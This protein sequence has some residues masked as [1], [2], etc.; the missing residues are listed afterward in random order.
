MD[1]RK[2]A[3]ALHKGAFFRLSRFSEA[4]R[5]RLLAGVKD[6]DEYC[7][8][9]NG[10]SL[11][12]LI[13]DRSQIDRTLGDY[14]LVRHSD[15]KRK[16]LGLVKHALLG[17]QH[18]FPGLKGNIP[19]AWAHVRTWEEEK[20]SK[21]RPPLPLAI[22][23]CVVGLARAHAFTAPDHKLREAWAIFSVLVEVG[24]FCLLRPGEILRLC[25]SDI[26]LPNNFVLCE[27]HAAVRILSPKNRRQFGDSQFVLLKN[28]NAISWLEKIHKENSDGLIWTKGQK[29]FGD[30]FRQLMKELKLSGCKF[31]P[32]SLR[33]GGATMYYSAGVS[34]STLRFMGRW[35]VERSLEHYIQLAMSAQIMNKLDPS[36]ITRLKRLALLCLQQVWLTETVTG[37]A[38][39]STVKKCDS[40]ELLNWCRAYSRLDNQ[41]RA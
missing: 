5:S 29:V 22:W 30:W 14:V 15:K 24:F 28:R 4:Y 21:L 11:G 9:E 8:H 23:L 41:C 25:H 33:P 40:L 2:K 18:L 35:S 31:T 3:K 10:L 7:M 37:I 34:V 17:A 20:V 6:L 13:T 27:K 12:S 1:R 16:Q 32:A 38:D 36:A 26:A 19:T 39:L